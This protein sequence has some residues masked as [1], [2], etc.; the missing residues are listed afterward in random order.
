MCYK[1]EISETCKMTHGQ[2]CLKYCFLTARDQKQLKCPSTGNSNYGVSINY[3]ALKKN[4]DTLCAQIKIV[5]DE[6][7]H[8]IHMINGKKHVETPI[9]KMI[10]IL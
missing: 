2:G 9:H 8:N 3:A 6:D 4:K 10:Y 1:M 5:D 7:S